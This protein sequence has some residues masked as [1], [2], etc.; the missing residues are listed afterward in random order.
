[1]GRS[2]VLF[3]SAALLHTAC[4]TAGP[5]EDCTEVIALERLSRLG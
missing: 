4:V 5:Q 2:S 1:M 3:V